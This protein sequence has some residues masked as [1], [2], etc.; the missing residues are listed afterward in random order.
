MSA[1]VADRHFSLHSQ[2][3]ARVLPSKLGVSAHNHE[4]GYKWW[5]IGD[6]IGC[7]LIMG[8]P[9]ETWFSFWLAASTDDF[10]IGGW[11]VQRNSSFIMILLGC[12]CRAETMTCRLSD[13]TPVPWY[14]DHVYHLWSFTRHL[15]TIYLPFT[16]NSTD[17]SLQLAAQVCSLCAACA[18]EA[19]KGN[20]LPRLTLPESHQSSWDELRAPRVALCAPPR[21]RRCLLRFRWMTSTELH[22]CN[23]LQ[24][25]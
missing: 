19:P 16:M 14:N 3:G 1:L 10:M 22:R 25:D 5:N 20:I 15:W 4:S 8:Q 6:V 9:Q 13:G 23:M 21:G 2:I 7:W 17:S 11:I 12:P 18:A 24:R